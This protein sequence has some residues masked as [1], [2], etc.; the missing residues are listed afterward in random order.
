ML[1]KNIK[2]Y[3][4]IITV[5]FTCLPANA[6]TME[7]AFV[8]TD[9]ETYV[10]GE[11]VFFKLYVLNNL[12]NKPS[13][14]SRFAYILLRP[15]NSDPAIKIRVSLSD[16]VSSGS[17]YLPDTLS[18]G[19]YQLVAYTS[20]MKNADQ[21]NL[22]NK[23]LMIFNRF[24]K[25][26]SFKTP[27]VSTNK[28]DTIT[29]D[30]GI[31]ISKNTFSTRETVK[32]NIGPLNE[33]ARLSVTV[34]EIP[35][36]SLKNKTIKQSILSVKDLQSETKSTSP[37]LLYK[38]LPET[39]GKILSGKVYDA[40]TDSLIPEAIV[41][42]SVTDS[43]PNLQYSKTD[44]E[45]NFKFLLNEYHDSKE[46][47]LTIYEKPE[48]EKWRIEVEDEYNILKSDTPLSDYQTKSKDY[49]A[50]S[51]NLVYI[52]K[53]FKNFDVDTLKSNYKTEFCFDK[54]YPKAEET[55]YTA[56]YVP[57]NDF[58]EISVEL[59]PSVRISK[60]SG[61]YKAMI[62]NSATGFFPKNNPA[63]FLDGVYVDD[64]EKI[65][66]LDSEK[67]KKIEVLNTERVFGNL[68]FQGIISI[69]S[70]GNEISKTKPA[71]YSTRVFNP[72]LN[73]PTRYKPAGS[74]NLS[75]K[76]IPFFKQLLYWNPDLLVEGQSTKEISFKT[77]DNTGDYEIN[78]EG[79][80]ESG[81]P[82]SINKIIKVSKS[83]SDNQ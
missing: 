5:F 73:I 61:K 46:L 12:D 28:A 13:K 76:S 47:F 54:V 70:K 57:L 82:V 27:D 50:K 2:I 21:K 7:K 31:Q 68:V 15:F 9:R 52:N 72:G 25:S 41:L 38:Y 64:I 49:I 67:I 55:I 40:F 14:I 71:Y 48:N 62:I 65:L 39:K 16:G 44:K 60:R 75:N 58:Q 81:K 83:K 26:F 19:V 37:A 18:S 53:V 11:N 17:F 34:H 59:L 66:D 35:E 32:F 1:S 30:T 42:L 22:F 45:G 77:S 29:S 24:D 6:L 78:I 43:I 79:I 36:L 74:E 80:T 69:V 4:F 33:D 20:L 63:I 10:A 8:H 3:F 56:D 23:Q 51:Q